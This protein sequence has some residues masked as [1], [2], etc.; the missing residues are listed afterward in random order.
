[1][2]QKVFLLL[3]LLL[4]NIV[5]QGHAYASVQTSL[6]PHDYELR[7]NVYVVY[8]SYQRYVYIDK[9]IFVSK[10]QV[11]HDGNEEDTYFKKKMKVIEPIVTLPLDQIITQPTQP[12]QPKPPVNEVTREL[13]LIT[14]FDFDRSDI[15][16]SE[17]QKLSQKLPELRKAELIEIKGFTDK[18]G[19]KEYNDKLALRRAKSVKQYLISNGIDEKKIKIEAKGKCCYVSHKDAENRRAEIWIEITT[20]GIEIKSGGS[21]TLR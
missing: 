14:N 6:L 10:R 9:P 7:N 2:G 21:H 4:L 11:V 18:I 13:S 3:S 5:A 1:M 16:R 8:P 17:L 15:K 20:G 12:I 19:T